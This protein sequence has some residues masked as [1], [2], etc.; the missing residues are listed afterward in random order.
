MSVKV[1]F[2]I[3]QLSDEDADA[4]NNG[5]SI[6]SKM[7]LTPDDYTLFHYKEGEFIQVETDHGLR[8]WCTITNLEILKDEKRV[9]TIFTLIKS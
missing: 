9:I 2:I 4:L 3:G 7:I 8:L 1:N 5:Y 6:I